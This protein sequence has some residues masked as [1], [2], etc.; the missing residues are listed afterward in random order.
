MNRVYYDI[1]N[2]DIIFKL[3]CLHAKQKRANIQIL[4]RISNVDN[5]CDFANTIKIIKK[6]F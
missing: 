1:E 3:F 4:Q 6:N 5:Y 2:R